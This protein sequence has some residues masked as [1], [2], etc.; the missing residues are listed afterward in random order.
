[1]A[2]LY[3]PHDGNNRR[4]GAVAVIKRKTGAGSSNTAKAART[5]AA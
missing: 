4:A 3:R 1:M 5:S 2:G